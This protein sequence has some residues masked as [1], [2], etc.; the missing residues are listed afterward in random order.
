MLEEAGWYLIESKGSH[1]QITHPHKPRGVTIPHGNRDLPPDT[2]A[3][4]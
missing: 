2:V 4:I 3:S 1:K